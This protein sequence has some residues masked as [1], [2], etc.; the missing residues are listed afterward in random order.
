MT[1]ITIGRLARAANCRVETVHYYERTGLMPAAARTPGGHRVYT[2]AEAKRLKFIRR[3]R[4]LGFGI[5]Q[6]RTLLGF[7]DEP[8]HSCG[9][10]RAVASAQARE[11]EA[12]IADLQRLK[13]AL[14]LMVS[15]CQGERYPVA[16]CPIVDALFNR[17][18]PADWMK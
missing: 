18:N 10:V 14:D 11:V 8:N 7:I 12:K 5:E 3:C 17:D 6:I 16:E 4:E 9:E 2:D 13:V 1:G 15:Q